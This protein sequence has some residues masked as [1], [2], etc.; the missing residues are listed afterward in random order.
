ML[1]A[2]TAVTPIEKNHNLA[3][4]D[5]VDM[6]DSAKYRRLFDCLI[7]LTITR[8]EL[9]YSV[10]ILAQFMQNLEV[11]HW[12]V[13]LRVVRYLKNSLG[14]GILFKSSSQLQLR[15]YC[16]A[17]WAT[18]PLTRRSLTSY[19]VLLG[20]SPISWKTKKQPTV[21]RSSTE[22][23]Y[24]SLAAVTSEFKWLKGMLF[25]FGIHHLAPMFIACDN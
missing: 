20:D 9:C 16:D 13:A 2:K 5:V 15:P 3:L 18:C 1:G 17:D 8:L 11:S 7:Y 6:V 25:A 14:Q 10:H 19:F 21:S 22:A 12:E 24:R 23:E 4:T